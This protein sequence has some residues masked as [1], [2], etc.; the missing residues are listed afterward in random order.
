MKKIPPYLQKGDCVVLISPARCVDKKDLLSFEK[1][2]TDQ[3]WVLEYGSYVFGK[4]NQF[5]SNDTQRAQD[6]VWAIEH[7]KAKAIFCAKGG[8]GSIRT[9][10]ALETLYSQKNHSGNLLVSDNLADASTLEISSMA[11]STQKNIQYDSNPIQVNWGLAFQKILSD[12]NPK[13]L[14]G[15]S[16][17]STLHL[18]LQKGNWASIHGPLA[19]QW[20]SGNAGIIAGAEQLSKVLTGE[21]V[22]IDLGNCTSIRNHSFEG[23]IVG[24]N[25]SLIY[26][27]LGTP[28][29]P[30]C[31]GKVL[32][33]EDIDE[34]LYHV[35]RMLRALKLAG[36]FE[37]LQGLIIGSM[38]DM[39]D[40][41]VP[42][43]Y[44]VSQMVC[45]ILAEY[46]FPILFDAPMGH[47][48]QNCAIKFGVNCT[49]DKTFLNQ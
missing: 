49:F 6:F 34:Y 9:L 30:K 47:G 18:A 45:E 13:W 31:R 32:F 15:F 37:G 29:Q 20:A 40:N 14:V 8:Y 44:T 35:D 43:G 26:A 39:K 16:D 12:A 33:I 1:W 19:S 2:V 23:E 17:I 21:S 48:Q 4:S 24:G 28:L 5:S 46:D 36:L 38:I 42:F 3:G 10:E 22:K 25:L 41:I 27:S 7:K 11:T